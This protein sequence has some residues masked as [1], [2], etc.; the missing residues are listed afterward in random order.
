MRGER[1][2]YGIPHIGPLVKKYNTVL[3]TQSRRSV[4]SRGYQ[5]YRHDAEV[6]SGRIDI[7]DLGSSIL[8]LPT[9]NT[10]QKYNAVKHLHCNLKLSHQ[11]WVVDRAVMYLPL[12][13]SYPG[14]TPGQP[15]K[16]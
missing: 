12:K 9:K 5:K 8:H 6:V 14:S 16:I 10:G 13:Q 4:T 11:L 1:N 7:A 3:I 15:T 2:P